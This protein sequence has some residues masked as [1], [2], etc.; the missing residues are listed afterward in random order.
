SKKNLIKALAQVKIWADHKLW[1]IREMSGYI[2]RKGLKKFPDTILYSLKTWIISEND[3]IRRISIE[4]LRPLSDIKWLRDPKKN[5]PILD[6]LSSLR[7]DPSVYVRKSVGNNLKDLSKYMPIKI[8]ELIE[9]WIH[10]AQINVVYN[11]ASKSKKELGYENFY[12]IWTIK[13]A[14]RWVRARNPEYHKK[15]E[16]LMGKNYVLY[17]DEKKNKLAKP[18]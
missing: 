6:I 10:E 9:K 11:L 14:L 3:N 8:L 5:D 13:H 12:L 4:S 7:A 1:E 17:F 15:I 2:I 18:K 16:K